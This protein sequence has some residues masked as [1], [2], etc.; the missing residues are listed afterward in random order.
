MSSHL[1]SI[2][3]NVRRMFSV[4]AMVLLSTLTSQAPAQSMWGFQPKEMA[5]AQRS[6]VDVKGNLGGMPVRISKEVA[7]F[8]EYD[9][10]P[11]WAPRPPGPPPQRTYESRLKSFG[12]DLRFPDMATMADPGSREDRQ[13]AGASRR[14]FSVRLTSGEIYPGDGFLDRRTH[15][16]LVK[17]GAHWF[18]QYEE[19]A[20]P[21]PAL[22]AYG[23][24]GMDPK[25]NTPY[26]TNQFAR[27]VFISRDETGK[28]RAYIDCKNTRHS[29]CEHDWSLEQL[30]INAQVTVIYRRELLEHW[31]QIQQE[32]AKKITS[33]RSEN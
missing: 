23:V 13:T 1:V 16:T 26:R 4:L 3:A 10:E 27:D 9:G 20:S 21:H 28:V 24:I 25:T 33:F 6:P 32:V 15:T 18:T 22:A 29:L 31:E 7:R 5:L 2:T 19:V 12:F 17:Q 8:A 14:W 30:G 11:T